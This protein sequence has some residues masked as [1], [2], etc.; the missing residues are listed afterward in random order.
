MLE[1]VKSAKKILTQGEEQKNEFLK[2]A[3]QYLQKEET[4]ADQLAI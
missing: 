4:E 1:E 3:T 2:I